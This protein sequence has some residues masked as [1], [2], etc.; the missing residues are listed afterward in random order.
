MP[1]PARVR[2]SAL[3]LENL[4]A[5]ENPSGLIETFNDLTPPAL[6]A[7]WSETSN[8]G[9]DVFASAAGAGLDS[10]VGVV[11]N[12][13]SRTSGFAS[14][15][16]S[17]PA[18]NGAAVSVKLDTL[19]PA[20]LFIR[21]SNLNT[22]SP[23]YVAATVT[24]GAK[25]TLS[26]VNNGA[27]KV[28]GSVVSPSSAYFSGGW[29]RVSLVP[30]DGNVA[31]RVQR[32]DTGDYLNAQG[33]WQKVATDALSATPSIPAAEGLAGIGRAAQYAGP[34]R[35]DNFEVIPPDPTVVGFSQ[36]FDTTAV[37]SQPEGWLSWASNSTGGFQAS[38]ARSLTP[39]NGYASSGSSANASRSW[40]DFAMPADV[41]ATASVYL[42]S[43]IPAQLLVRGSALDTADPTYYAVSV[44]RGL[45]ARLVKVV[46]GA[47]TTLATLKSDAYFSSKWLRVTLTAQGD[48]LQ[49]M[50]YDPATRQWLAADGAWSGSP[51]FAFDLHDG[52]ITGSGDVGLARPAKFAGTI[53]FDDFEAGPAGASKGPKVDVA[54]ISGT[55]PAI[56]DITF[57]ATATGSVTRVEFRLNNVIR[58]ASQTAPAEWTFDTTSVA[59]GTYTLTVRAFDA[60]GN[61]GTK[62]VTFTVN[63]PN[64][65]PVP[66]PT[67]PRHYSHI[68][69]AELAYSGNPMGGFEQK[70]LRESVD[71]VIPNTQYLETIDA[72][73]PDTPQL[74]YSNVSNL[75]QGLLTNWLEYAD[76]HGDS[77]ELG[78]Y[79]VTKPTPFSG[80]SPTSQPVTWFWGVYQTGASGGSPVDVTSAARGGRNFNVNFGGT[81][82]TTAVGFIEKFR[83]MNVTL[84]SGAQAVWS[85]V[86]EY[87]SAVDAN[88]NPTEW[89]TLSLGN[90]GTAGLK[91]SGTIS[92]DP[93]AD[94]KTA[95]IGG[96]SGQYFVRF[97]VTGGTGAEAPEL[98][99]IFGR[100]YVI[101]NGGFTGTIPAFDYAADKNSDGYLNDTEYSSREAGKDAR[102]IYETRLF[103]PFYGQMRFV[104]NP[105]SSAIRKWAADYHVQLLDQ[106]PLA[107]GIFMDN[108]SGKLPFPGVS[109][110]EP[111]STFSLDSGSLIAAVNRAI[112]PHWV[113]AN[114]AGSRAEGNA[115]AASSAAVIE[116]F[117]LRPQQANWSEVGDVANLVAG[118][119]NAEGSPY[120]VLDSH[121]AGGHPLS[122]RT[123]I[124]TL[125]YYYL[126]ADPKRTFLMFYGGFSPSTTWLQH[127]SDAAKVDVG[128]PTGAM[129]V[130]ASGSDPLSPM[131]DYKVYARD[132]E[133]A[134]VLYKPLS[135]KQSIGEGTLN[136]WTAT[137]H[138]LNGNYR[139]VNAD[140]TL[141][142]V[143]NSI[144]L[145]NGE[146]A[147]LIKA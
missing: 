16:Q 129:K 35:I 134:L 110:L 93:P 89:K 107:D 128:Q 83:E 22:D 36:S 66:K 76:A 9:T 49:A 59:N 27:S 21:G 18:D 71:I 19:V 56:G 34:V 91:Q 25:V 43:L 87:V 120:V 94:W 135:Y 96:S 79:H 67:I 75:Y 47:E 68:R 86:W 12:G 92:F 112:A 98:K 54:Q 48:R 46:N 95:S 26:E 80:A 72:T 88:G 5:R 30:V 50:L 141:G 138:Q 132:Y 17:L 78:F 111:T 74:I 53:T 90:D 10:S 133:N 97:R 32:L 65:D 8:D 131:L 3:Q 113:M 122:D 37:G 40:A 61:F 45:E 103:Y 63:N 85:G 116:E 52:A 123:Q 60:A 28:L 117:L 102:F 136:D 4:E 57:R 127:W 99:T 139:Q 142:P 126:L 145:R 140:G 114:T 24:R 31:V 108:A 42:D 147:V 104:T 58:A 81:G 146:G 33:R 39:A 70:L 1:H 130:F 6:P 124:G 14:Y 77:R 101:A 125:A 100:D 69:I 44:T 2:R 143:V 51:E 109:V 73:S 41:T 11:A 13:G 15:P 115:I 62:D 23:S 119:L 20:F 55:S 84:V 144:R 137:T 105:S 82:Q 106:N 118:R 64:A 38:N 121:P 7:G 29:V